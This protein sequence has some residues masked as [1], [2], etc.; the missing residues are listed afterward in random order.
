MGEPGAETIYYLD[1]IV[2]QP[3]QGKALLDLYMTSY[4]PKA[5]SRGMVLAHR[6]VTPPLWLEGQSNEL[7]IIW[8]VQGVAAWWAATRMRRKDPDLISF[9]AEALPLIA[10]RQR[11]YL[12]DVDDVASLCSV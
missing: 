11:L 5:K 4:V 6:W 3:G 10:K 2:A 8:T 9:W 12:S 7:F 1:H